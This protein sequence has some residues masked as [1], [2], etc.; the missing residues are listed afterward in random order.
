MKHDTIY[1]FESI[2]G[3]IGEMWKIPIFVEFTTKIDRQNKGNDV[4]IDT[5]VNTS[6]ERLCF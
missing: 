6:S 3:V 1:E 5:A 4:A 2:L